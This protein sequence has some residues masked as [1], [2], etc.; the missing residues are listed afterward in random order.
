M[1]FRIY[2][3]KLNE[4]ECAALR[5]LWEDMGDKFFRD[6]CPVADTG[7]DGCKYKNLCT[8]LEKTQLYLIKG[9][10]A[11]AEQGENC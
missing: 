3:T 9:S 5:A 6:I 11:G 1:V 10:D 8:G 4:S 2:S 7:C